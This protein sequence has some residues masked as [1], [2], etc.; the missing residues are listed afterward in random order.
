[1][2]RSDAGIH[3]STT[4][5]QLGRSVN[6]AG[7]RDEESGRRRT[8]KSRVDLHRSEAG[9]HPLASFPNRSSIRRKRAHFLPDGNRQRT[10][11]AVAGILRGS[12]AAGQILDCKNV[13]SVGGFRPRTKRTNLP[14]GRAG[15][16]STDPTSRY[17]SWGY[18]GT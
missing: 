10:D 14:L 4:G 2:L 18:A 3:R 13:R 11:T 17:G 12:E 6:R 1:D 16:T 5:A 15:R 8:A 9:D 7:R